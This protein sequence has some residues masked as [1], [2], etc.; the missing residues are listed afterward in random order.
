MSRIFR[1]WL[2]QARSRSKVI[3]FVN[4]S[5]SI[6]HDANIMQTKITMHQA[7]WVSKLH[8]LGYLYHTVIYDFHIL[9]GYIA[10][11]IKLLLLDISVHVSIGH[12]T[13][14]ESINLVSSIMI[15]LIK[16]NHHVGMGRQSNPSID[17]FIRSKL[18]DRHEASQILVVHN[19]LRLWNHLLHQELVIEYLG[20]IVY[21]RLDNN[22]LNALGLQK[23]CCTLSTFGLC[24][25]FV[26]LLVV[27]RSLF[28][29]I[30]QLIY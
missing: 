12:F 30:L 13:Q 21:D 23:L 1:I 5:N 17:V 24:A 15:E 6:L 18:L 4:R 28:Q 7:M 10:I 26:I 14:T 25:L 22:V 11:Q 3:Y 27:Q 19:E 9:R 29:L 16:S 20:S 8:A 2:F